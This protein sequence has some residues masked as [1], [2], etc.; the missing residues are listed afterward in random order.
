MWKFT[1][2]IFILC[3]RK[4]YTYPKMDNIFQNRTENRKGNPLEKYD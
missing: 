2:F 4:G 1:S 3:Y